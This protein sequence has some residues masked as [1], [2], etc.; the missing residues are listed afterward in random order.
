MSGGNV[1]RTH[2]RTAS[3]LRK[4]REEGTIKKKENK[5]KK[6]NRNTKAYAPAEELVEGDVPC[7]SGVDSV[8]GLADKLPARGREAAH[9]GA[10]TG[11]AVDALNRL[12]VTCSL[13]QTLRFW[14]FGDHSLSIE[15][16]QVREAHTR[17]R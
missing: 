3:T 1:E 14:N 7:A 4:K 15:P 11:V 8:E 2:A 9:S 6:T 16:P 13:D 5:Q 10:V 12:L 17:P